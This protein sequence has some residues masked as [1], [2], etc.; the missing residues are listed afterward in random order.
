MPSCP[1]KRYLW[2]TQAVSTTLRKSKT[3]SKTQA[4]I[5]TDTFL[6]LLP[7]DKNEW[8]AELPNISIDNLHREITLAHLPN[9]FEMPLQ[10]LLAE[11]IKHKGETTGKFLF[12]LV[13]GATCKIA[14]GQISEDVVLRL[15]KMVW[16]EQ[17]SRH[18][19]M[20]VQAIKLID[21][22]VQARGSQAY[23]L[24]LCQDHEDGRL[25]PKGVILHVSKNSLE[26]LEE[27]IDKDPI[28]SVETKKLYIPSLVHELLGFRLS[29]NE[30]C[31]TL[32]VAPMMDGQEQALHVQRDFRLRS[33]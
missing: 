28:A 7:R 9:R 13:F 16:G 29:L 10:E 25:K 18:L 14:L 19:D 21:I 12:E 3:D 23:A 31:Q 4:K 8:S 24:P 20:A 2:R 26:Y 32:Q 22:V 27:M 5:R 11:Y 30:I 17:D 15:M 1:Q 33:P 6:K